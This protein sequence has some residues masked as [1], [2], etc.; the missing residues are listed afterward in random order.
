MKV[1][2]AAVASLRI[3]RYTL[4]Q[5]VARAAMPIAG[6]KQELEIPADASVGDL[7]KAA[8]AAFAFENVKEAFLM[9]DDSPVPEEISIE[10][11]GIQE[12]SE[13]PVY[14]AVEI[15]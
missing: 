10:L 3:M 5:E 6:K 14:F 8:L 4:Q 12:G 2:I 11:L 9:N 7:A 1:T 13:V 15:R